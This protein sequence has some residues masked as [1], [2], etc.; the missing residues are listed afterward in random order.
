MGAAFG[1][2]AK[3]CRCL[4]RRERGFVWVGSC[5][6][7]SGQPG[8]TSGKE[9]KGRAPGHMKELGVWMVGRTLEGPI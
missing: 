9:E 4:S 3:G 2:E 7:T 8:G 5:L 6:G 1:E